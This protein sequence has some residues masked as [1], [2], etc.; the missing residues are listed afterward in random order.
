MGAR[1]SPPALHL[2]ASRVAGALGRELGVP[3]VPQIESPRA[4]SAVEMSG[5][6]TRMIQAS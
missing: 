5:R 3:F 2:L 1:R 4:I 6:I